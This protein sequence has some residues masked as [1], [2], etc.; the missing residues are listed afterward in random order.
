MVPAHH[1]SFLG[2]AALC[3]LASITFAEEPKPAVAGPIAVTELKRSTTV[4]FQKEILPLFKKSCTA[5]HNQTDAKGDLVLESPKT[6]LVGGESGPAVVPG[7]SGESLLLKLAAHQAKPTMPPKNNKANAPDLKPDELGL[8]KLWIDQGAKGEV[9]LRETPIVWQPLPAGLNPIYAIAVSPDGQYVAAGRANQIFIYHVPTKSLV[10][11][12]T[13]PALMQSG[14]YK[15]PGNAHLDLV[16]SLAFNPQGDLLASGGYRVVKIWRKPQDVQKQ[17]MALGDGSGDIAISPDGKWLA[18]AQANHTIKLYSL[19]D[20]KPVREFSGHTAKVN[21]FAFSAD[22]SKLLTSSNDKTVRLF[23]V[24]DGKEVGKIDAPSEVNSVIWLAKEAKIATGHADHHV[25]IWDVKQ[26]APQAVKEPA[27]EPA[28]EKPEADKAKEETKPADGAAVAVAPPAPLVEIK[29]GAAITAMTALPT[30]DTQLLAGAADG[31]VHHLSSENNK[32]IKQFSHGAP[33]TSLAIRPDGLKFATA[34]GN[35]AKLWKIDSPQGVI[36]VKGNPRSSDL[37]EEKQRLIALSDQHVA[38]YKKLVSDTEGR[39]KAETDALT[40][41]NEAVKKAEEE[42][43]AKSDAFVK[44][45]EAKTKADAAMTEAEAKLKQA[46]EAKAAA[47]ATAVKAKEEATASAAKAT[48]TASALTKATAAKTAAEQ[49]HNDQQAKLKAS[50]EKVTAAKAELA[51]KADDQAKIDALSAAEKELAERTAKAKAAE[52]GFKATAVALE[53]ATKLNAD[54][55]KNKTDADTRKQAADK[56]KTDGDKALADATNMR[57]TAD[58]QVKAQD[59]PFNDAK[60]ATE[61]AQRNKDSSINGVAN[62]TTGVKR[63]EEQLTQAQASTK[64]AEDDKTKTTA[65]VEAAKKNATD[66]IKAITTVAFSANGG[67]L[68]TGGEAQVVQTWNGDD[69]SPV[70]SYRGHSGAVQNVAVLSDGNI[71]SA[72]ADHKAIIWDV[73]APWKLE[74]NIGSGSADSPLIDRVLSLAFSPDGKTLATGGG[75]PS[76]SGEVKLWNMADGSLQREIKDAHSDTVFGIEFSFDG[77]NLATCAAD[78]FVKTWTVSDGKFIMSFEGHTHHVLGVSW[79]ADGRTLASS[80]A[81]GVVKIW[82]FVIGGQKRTIKGGDKEIT[83]IEFVG[84]S[85]TLLTSAA[86]NT[87]RTI[88]DNGSGGKNMPGSA[89]AMYC[90]AITPDG[91]V[92]AAGG[93]DSV[94]RVWNGAGAEIAKFEVPKAEGK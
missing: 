1:W 62:V 79:A 4:D 31:N 53:S 7:K 12:L 84:V 58:Q 81:D 23:T 10:T 45:T 89:D 35:V 17:Q 51:K 52:D 3:T 71:L 16:Q 38:Y 5:C 80:G 69:G 21:H 29:L 6:I 42:L 22:S 27:K 72:A 77:K 83:S 86:D 87:V 48:E 46:M 93:Q 82:D 40:K 19:A 44:A 75:Q 9:I 54:A 37:I 88:K 74:R 33:V 73:A 64:A 90:A 18:T 20:G 24:S 92:I 43:K 25:R 2:A 41:A 8:I 78:K 34:G 67:L 76:R 68:V 66:A 49:A 15:Q 65:D 32:P 56:V 11:R 28:K 50:T 94:V 14:L 60:A 36:E 91:N 30:N 70:A 13:D 63:V 55:Q 59:K 85:D 57:N 47:E 39:K 26:L 61:S